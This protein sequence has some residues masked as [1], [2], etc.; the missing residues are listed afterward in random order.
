MQMSP[1]QDSAMSGD[2]AEAG[3]VL[4]VDIGWAQKHSTTGACR[5]DWSSTTVGIECSCAPLKERSQLLR[6]QA[7][8][9]LLVAALDGPLRGDLGIIGHYRRAEQLLTQRLGQRIGKP[10]QSSSPVSTLLNFHANECARILLETRKVGYAVHD[11]AIH[12]SAI[13]EAF[14]SSFLGVLIEQPEL[15]EVDRAHR[16]DVFYRH[17]AQS[18]VLLALLQYLL[19]N[20]TLTASFTEITHHDESAAVICALAALCI[21]AGH[22]T[23]VGDKT[24]GWIVLPPRLFIR[25]WA[26]VMLEKNAKRGGLEFRPA[27][28][29]NPFPL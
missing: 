25:P 28:E 1:Q 17:L 16:S 7:D 26:R 6:D 3:S 5:L 24:D 2:I 4:G 10:G 11:H 23:V 29:F 22:Y 13:V 14:P 21:A 15:L 20:R 9:R 18:S 8:R 19:P 12:R 27:A